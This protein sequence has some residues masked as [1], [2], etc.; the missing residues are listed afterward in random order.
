MRMKILLATDTYHPSVN[1]AAYFTYRLAQALAQRGHEVFVLCPS[2]SFAHTVQVEAGVTVYGIRSIPIFVYR[3]FRISPAVFSRPAIERL[4]KNIAPDVVHIQNHFMIGKETVRVARAL[5]IPTMGTNH[6][7]PENLLH[8]FHLPHAQEAV[9]KTFGWKQC[10]R[11]FDQLDVVTTPTK[12]AAALLKRAGLR[13]EVLSVS[14]GIDLERFSPQNDGTYL[15]QRY[16]IPE[17]VPVVLSVGRLDKEKRIEVTLRAVAEVIRQTPVHF[18]LAGI[19]KEQSTLETLVQELG[20]Q[21][22][23]TFAGFVP[24]EDLQNLYPVADIFVTAGIAEL[25]S[26]VTMEAMASGL[27]VVA[28]NAM[29]L[30]EL[31]HHG[32]NGFLFE[33]GDSQGLAQH[34]LALLNN[35]V[36]RRQMA[37]RS[38]EIIQAHDINKTIDAYESLYQQIVNK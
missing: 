6:F 29:A 15:K 32:E 1:G 14:C 8:Y 38:L 25:Q 17:G 13:Q 24:D 36:L 31:V 7:M 3:N 35:D 2:Q 12:T 34:L 10:I 19:G 27:P 37:A 5:G 22:A 18:V 28:V 20:I 9:L 30:P 26:L 21:D 16:Q 23:V 11:V 33:D 4:V